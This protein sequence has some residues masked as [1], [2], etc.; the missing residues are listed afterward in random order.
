MIL[1]TLALLGLGLVAMTGCSGPGTSLSQ[2][3]VDPTYGGGPIEKVLVIGIL[4][5]DA[6]Q[7]VF[8]NTLVSQFE[9]LGVEAVASWQVIPADKETD[10]E[11]V[12]AAIE[13]R[14]FDSVMVSQLISVDKRQEYVPGQ[15]YVGSYWGSPH[16]GYGYYPYYSSTYA[17]VHEPGYTIE[18]TVVSVET[19]IYDV[20]SEILKWAA[21]SETLNPTQVNSAIE[22]F[23]HVLIGDLLQQGLVVKK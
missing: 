22:G 21:I 2:V 10:E 4:K 11:S 15:T 16:Y 23:G 20:D 14:G 19:N 18:N 5:E 12:K 6:R 8:E 17:V 1:R 7:R 9:K 13:G 3:W